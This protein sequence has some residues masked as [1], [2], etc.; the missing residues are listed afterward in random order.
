MFGMI[1][2]RMIH[3]T[4][5]FSLSLKASPRRKQ[6]LFRDIRAM[7]SYKVTCSYMYLKRETKNVTPSGLSVRKRWPNVRVTWVFLYLWKGGFI[8]DCLFVL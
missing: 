3:Y 6:F 4:H 5:N 1:L 7:C 2:F 8:M